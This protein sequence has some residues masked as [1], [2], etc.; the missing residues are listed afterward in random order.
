[1]KCSR[2]DFWARFCFFVFLKLSVK[3][4]FKVSHDIRNNWRKARTPTTSVYQLTHTA[5]LNCCTLDLCKN[6]LHP[7]LVTFV[8]IIM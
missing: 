3:R 4:E 7:D 6:W 2:Q 1:M 5:V 8:S